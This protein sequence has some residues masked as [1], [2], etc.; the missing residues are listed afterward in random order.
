VLIIVRLI[1][2]LN[3]FVRSLRSATTGPDDKRHPADHADEPH[4]D[5]RG[6]TDLL[7]APDPDA[8]PEMPDPYTVLDVTSI[9]PAV[10][11][12]RVCTLCLEERHGTCAT[13][14]GHL[15]D[16]DCIY[17]WGREKVRTRTTC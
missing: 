6:M 2:R 13:E 4:I 5:G 8:V 15:F 16:W 1:Y 12:G 7:D 10:R 14:C 9:P 11:A 3:V 17:G